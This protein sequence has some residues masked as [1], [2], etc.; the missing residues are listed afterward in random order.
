MGN[1]DPTG[2]APTS[3]LESSDQAITSS[4]QRRGKSYSMP[5][6]RNILNVFISRPWFVIFI[7]NLSIFQ[8]TIRPFTGYFVRRHKQLRHIMLKKITC[9]RTRKLIAIKEKVSLYSNQITFN[10]NQ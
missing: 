2:K 6:M 9:N 5:G 4:K 1:W 3:Y 8:L 10:Y 7:G